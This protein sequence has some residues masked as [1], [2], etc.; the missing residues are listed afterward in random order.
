MKYCPNCGTQN[1]D[2]AQVCTNCGRAFTSQPA[3]TVTSPAATLPIRAETL[4]V[5][6]GFAAGALVLLILI[7]ISLVGEEKSRTIN[8]VRS[9]TDS[10]LDL[11]VFGIALYAGY[12][13]IAHGLD[14]SKMFG[15][16]PPWARWLL[17]G[18]V[19][20]LIFLPASFLSNRLFGFINF[21]AYEVAYLVERFF[22][23]VL[24]VIVSGVVYWRLS[25]YRSNP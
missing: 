20:Y 17:A 18:I 3:P 14:L 21:R 2:D 16:V 11:Y 1:A 6:A 8:I 9:I 24:I 10:L 25:R 12:N 22:E 15:G 13:L 23:S 4:A 5:G 19:G 7:I